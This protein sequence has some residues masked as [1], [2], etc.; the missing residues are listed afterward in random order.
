MAIFLT[1]GETVVVIECFREAGGG[2][3]EISTGDEEGD[4][5]M[6]FRDGVV[7]VTVPFVVIV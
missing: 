6:R 7:C 2:G 1:G 3:G 4:G 5:E